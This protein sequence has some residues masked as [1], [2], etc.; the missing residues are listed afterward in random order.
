M[1]SILV[2]FLS[3]SQI[4]IWAKQEQTMVMQSSLTNKFNG[5]QLSK[6]SE[7]V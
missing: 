7:F 6:K 2:R 1:S 3:N 5:Q 4:G